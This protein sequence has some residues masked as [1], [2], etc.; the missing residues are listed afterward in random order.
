MIFTPKVYIVDDV[1]PILNEGLTKQGFEVIYEPH[2]SKF[3]LVENLKMYQPDVLVLRS[4]IK[5]DEQVLNACKSLKLIAR[6]GA[7]MDNINLELAKQRGIECI[8][9]GEANSDAVG[10][11]TLGLLLNGL[12]NISKSYFE[13]KKGIWLREENRG[14]ELSQKTVG[15][16]GYGNTGR[17]V[18]KR[19]VS[20][21]CQVLVYDKY[22]KGYG[23]ELHV[24]SEMERI[25][26]EADVLTL[27]IPLTDETSAMVDSN[28]LSAFKK[29]IFL[30]NLSRGPIVKTSALIEALENNKVYK[31]ALDVLENE[32]LMN[33]TPVQKKEFQFLAESDKVILTPHIG[34]WTLE[35]YD[36]ISA[37]LLNKI[38]ENF[39]K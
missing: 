13:V 30:M 6:A 11:H 26:E 9:A 39:K 28:F 33:L 5:I 8:N 10:D 29:S 37:V 25:F 22:L 32:D 20:F 4:K 2:V 34:G 36:K 1:S 14:I 23:N 15:I 7:G 12:R 19:L 27:H 16:I 17:A 24:E 3:Q 31:C 38:I 21:G 35:S 18:A